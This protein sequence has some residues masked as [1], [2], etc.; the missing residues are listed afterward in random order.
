MHTLLVVTHPNP[1]SLTH[2][3]AGTIIDS[4]SNSNE[5]NTID[6]L[7]LYAEGFNPLFSEQ[8][9]AAARQQAN[10]PSDVITLQK[11][12]DAAQCLVLVFPVHWW[13]M[14]AML[15]GWVDRVFTNGW[16]Y[17]WTLENGTLKKLKGLKVHVFC[18]GASKSETYMQRGYEAAIKKTIGEGMF[19]YVGASVESFQVLGDSESPECR[20]EIIEKAHKLAQLISGDQ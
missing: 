15:K 19:N 18:I 7:D 9:M 6:F 13:G 4:L 17:E 11:R 16:A 14:P 8:D 12:I 5:K 20:V 2:S 3:L 10:L 1:D